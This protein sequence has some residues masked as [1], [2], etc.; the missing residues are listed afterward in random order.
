MD[1]TK[2]PLGSQ[3]DD[4]GGG[5]LTRRKFLGGAGALVAGSLTGPLLTPATTAARASQRPAAGKRPQRVAVVGVDHY[6]ATSTP[7]YLRLLQ[8][9][10]VEIVGVHAPEQ[11][12]AEKWAGQY[13]STPYT[14]YRA[15][16]EKTRPEFVIALG[17]HA[18][19]PAEFR[20]LVDTGIPF[21]MEKPWGIDDKTVNELAALAESKKAWAAVPMPFRYSMFAET[22][23]AMRDKGELGAISHGIL[24][25]NQPGIQR[26][27]DLGSP[28]MLSKADAGGG[29]LINLGIH[30]FDICRYLTAEEPKVVS[31][32]TSRV[33]HNQ[34]IEDY[35]HVTLR[36]PKGVIFHVEA[37]YTFPG[38]GGDQERKI[39]AQKALLRATLG[40]GEGVEIIGPGR[41]ETVR[42]PQ[43]YL[44]GWPRVV[45]ECLNRIGRGEPP[46][47]T[48]RDCARSVSLICDAYRMAG[49][50]VVRS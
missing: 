26:Y 2:T 15:M 30:G 13:G 47:M 14:D 38:T 43:G 23:V 37:S 39:S 31:A 40:G 4:A 10:K 28:W 36:T 49:E 19:M 24:R 3:R 35:A 9:Q 17:R 18:A 34:E 12:T 8:G 22:A 32:V 7:N 25:F 33:V 42:A 21:L 48:A 1:E 27:R 11:A 50:K 41:N 44:S 6:H 16:I 29:A 46:P 20:F 5:G 45:D